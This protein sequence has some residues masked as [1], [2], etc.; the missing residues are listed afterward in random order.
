MGGSSSGRAGTGSSAH[1]CV[2]TIHSILSRWG[3]EKSGR[4]TL[5]TQD[6]HTPW[7]VGTGAVAPA[8]E[9]Q[10]PETTGWYG[11]D[12]AGT[13][14]ARMFRFLLKPKWIAFTL[15]IIVLT[16]GMVRAGFWQWDK[17]NKR[18]AFNAQVRERAA[19]T[20]S[21]GRPVARRS[22][23]RRVPLGHRQ[24]HLRGTTL[25]AETD[26]GYWVVTPMKLDSGQTVLVNRGR[27][28]TTKSVPETPTGEV[29]LQ[30]RLRRPAKAIADLDVKA[31]DTKL[32]I[33]A[34]TSTPSDSG[35]LTPEPF[36]DLTG[37][38]PY[39]PYAVQWWIF[40]GCA[41]VGW[42][43]VVRRQS[44]PPSLA[45]RKPGKGHHQAVP[46]RDS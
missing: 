44:R 9:P 42:V 37:G 1:P 11:P 16:A 20:P 10:R 22:G 5:T 46:W 8:Q 41:V 2:S 6:C 25:T 17:H 3:I 21:L 26:G 36:P 40:S 4:G 14:D 34:Q 23:Q 18:D 24:R 38:P 32:L 45:T 12:P 7:R 30:G 35:D 19:A 27:L 33:E 28:P 29:T 15:L 39:L 43:L 13:V 31:A